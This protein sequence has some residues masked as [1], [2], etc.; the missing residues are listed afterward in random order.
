MKQKRRKKK[1]KLEE[2]GISVCVSQRKAIEHRKCGK[3]LRRRRE[4]RRRH[5][6]K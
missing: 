3:R 5:R 2:T 6:R 4:R 1:K